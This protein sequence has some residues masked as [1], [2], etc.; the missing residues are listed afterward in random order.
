MREMDTE[1]TLLEE[2]KENFSDLTDTEHDFFRDIEE[3]E[4]FRKV[5]ELD[6]P[7]EN[8]PTVRAKCLS[9]LLQKSRIFR[10]I[11]SR[12]K[13]IIQG[14]HIQGEISCGHII[15][16]KMLHFSFCYFSDKIYLF[17]SEFSSITFD[18]SIV[19]QDI[20]ANHVE[21]KK[22]FS[23]INGSEAHNCIFLAEAHIGGSLVFTGSTVGE[24]PGATAINA[25]AVRIGGSVILQPLPN[26]WFG[27][28]CFRL[29]KCSRCIQQF[30]IIEAEFI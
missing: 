17:Y 24:K 18:H 9:W 12:S 10:K 20:C 5:S 21:I 26:Q 11:D 27:K 28:F 23:F 7:S 16:L 13:I 25:T 8:L 4:T 29:C 22:S 1:K 15:L 2:A 30:F 19:T 6:V 3:K 14:V